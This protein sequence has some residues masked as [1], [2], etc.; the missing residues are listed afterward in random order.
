MPHTVKHHI[1]DMHFLCSEHVRERPASSPLADELVSKRFEPQ[2][3]LNATSG[4][5]LPHIGAKGHIAP[6]QP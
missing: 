3:A 1:A 2:A 6:G 5:L 4:C